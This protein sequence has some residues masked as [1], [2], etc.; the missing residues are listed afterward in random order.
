LNER[1]H[2]ENLGRDRWIILKQVLK[3]ELESMD[4]IH[5]TEDREQ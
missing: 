3:M 1:D 5:L 2:C 4:W